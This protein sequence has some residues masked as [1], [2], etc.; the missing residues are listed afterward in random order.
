MKNA[1]FFLFVIFLLA[2][3]TQQI[4][5]QAPQAGSQETISQVKVSF[6]VND[7][8]NNILEKTVEVEKGTIALDAL[9]E[10]TEVKGKQ[11]EFGFFVESIAGVEAGQSHYWAIYVDNV[12]AEK[13]IDQIVLDKDANLRFVLEEI[14][15]F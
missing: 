7:G 8:E 1:L 12:Y 10:A 2:G 6:A 4:Q 3:C 11:Y 14:R 15:E 5:Q 9:R 13:G